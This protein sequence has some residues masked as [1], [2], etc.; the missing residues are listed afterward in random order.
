[1]DHP[2]LTGKNVY[3]YIGV[4][5]V[6]SGAHIAVLRIVVDI[7][8]DLAMVDGIV[9]NFLVAG[10]GLSYWFVIKYGGFQAR[11]RLTTFASHFVGGLLIIGLC[12]GL[13]N[14][15]T[16]NYNNIGQH[17]VVIASPW[18][19]LLGL[20]YYSIIVLFYYLVKSYHDLQNR[21]VNE[22]RLET[23]IKEAELNMLK[24][25]I[26]PHFIFNSLNSISA[27]TLK[28][29]EDARD[30]IVKLSDFLRYSLG[31]ED[32]SKSSLEDEL[33]NIRL[34][35]EIEKVRFGEKLNFKQE[36]D[37]KALKWRMPNMILQ[38]LMENAVKYGVY[39]SI[40]IALVELMAKVEGDRLVVS[41]SNSFEPHTVPL[42]GKGIGLKN[43]GNRLELIY[44]FDDLLRVQK[45]ENQF[46]ATLSIPK[47]VQSD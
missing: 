10:L 19:I 47:S 31:N 12:V 39:E 43:V 42:K 46:I 8:L 2:F 32:H 15:V 33:N 4:W 38:P 22:S 24:N 3:Y 7:P 44:N 29:P 30:M 16:T 5:A 40:N 20:F 18:K 41:I 14:F 17:L 11:N 1:M 45:L 35:M 36:I 37:P 13:S 27:L 25:Q 34:Y 6:I 21:S 28:R 9:F 23:E 26:N